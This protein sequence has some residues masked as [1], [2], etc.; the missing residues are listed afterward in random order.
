M[1]IKCPNCKAENSLL[2]EEQPQWLRMQVTELE[3]DDDGMLIV[4][5]DYDQPRWDD[6]LDSR[7]TCDECSAILSAEDFGADF[8]ES[9]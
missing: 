5:A 3:L 6:I 8:W 1:K 9:A 2:Y 7:L 4:K